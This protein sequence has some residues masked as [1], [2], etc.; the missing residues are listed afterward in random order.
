M[1][2]QVKKK[3]EVQDIGNSL[4]GLEMTGLLLLVTTKQTNKKMVQQ[5]KNKFNAPLTS[6]EVK[7]W[8]F[9]YRNRKRG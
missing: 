9:G 4:S 6:E 8:M 2:E 5:L 1:E 7:N 3:K